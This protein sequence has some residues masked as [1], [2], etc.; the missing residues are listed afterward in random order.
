M[1]VI[2]LVVV[3]TLVVVIAVVTMARQVRKMGGDFLLNPLLDVVSVNVKMLVVFLDVD[4][5]DRRRRV[6]QVRPGVCRMRNRLSI[7]TS[8]AIMRV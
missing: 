1:V 4:N 7:L 8:K 5:L 2:A 3:I 6:A